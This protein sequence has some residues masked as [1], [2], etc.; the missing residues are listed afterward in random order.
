MAQ[1]GLS[2]LPAVLLALVLVSI[3]PSQAAGPLQSIAARLPRLRGGEKKSPNAPIVVVGSVNADI[4]I[5]VDRLPSAGETLTSRNP[6]SGRMIPGGKG[7]NQAVAAARLAKS[8]TVK[9]A[10]QFGNDDHAKKLEQALKDNKLDLSACGH[11]KV[12]PSGQGYVLLEADGSVSSIV[13]GG[14]N[15]AWPAKLNAL[16]NV[17]RGASAVMLQCEVPERVNEVAAAAAAQKGVPVILDVGG[18]DRALSDKLLKHITYISLNLSELARV[19]G[20]PTASD[21]EI[22]AAAQRLQA[23][24][25]RNVLITL[26]EEGAM[27]LCE[28]GKVLRET[29][30]PIPGGKMVDATAAGDCYRAAFICALVQGRSLEECM[31]LGSAAGAICVSRL[32]AIPSLPFADEVGDLCT[33]TFGGAQELS[34]TYAPPPVMPSDGTTGREAGDPK[35]KPMR[36]SLK[37]LETRHSIRPRVSGFGIR[38]LSET[39][40][41][42]T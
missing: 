28:G 38:S 10:C 40:A 26:G 25:A 9:F 17:V 31:Q 7:A 12:C 32:G 13:V 1:F 20:L 36:H 16:E 3:S 24:G 39:H 18:E 27:L 34:G 37:P 22:A 41:S 33:E 23:Q 42:C 14:A 35:P 19:T 4:I 29:S 6:N 15:V 5:E 21:D 11:S 8:S 2:I 30:C